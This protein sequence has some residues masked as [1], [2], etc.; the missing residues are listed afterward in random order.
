MTE[1]EKQKIISQIEGDDFIS[2]LDFGLQDG[3]AH[4]DPQI[5]QGTFDFNP[6]GFEPNS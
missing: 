5:H 3:T 6:I 2:G 4:S 1:A